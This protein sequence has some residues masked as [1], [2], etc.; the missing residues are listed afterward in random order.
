MLPPNTLVGHP[1]HLILFQRKLPVPEP[2]QQQNLHPSPVNYAPKP[3][4]IL[5][6]LG[7]DRI[8]RTSPR[9]RY[10]APKSG[11]LRPRWVT[12]NPPAPNRSDSAR[13][14]PLLSANNGTVTTTRFLWFSIFQK[15]GVWGRPDRRRGDGPCREL[16]YNLRIELGHYTKRGSR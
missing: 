15:P 2:P 14:N 10:R 9:T 13:A 12:P 3:R 16:A 6:Y 4:V 5:Q 11:D 7:R 8:T 1:R